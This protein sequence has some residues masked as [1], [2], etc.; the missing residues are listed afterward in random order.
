MSSVWVSKNAHVP[1][2]FPRLA[3]DHVGL[4]SD[5]A[6]PTGLVIHGLASAAVTFD[7]PTRVLH[8]A[9]FAVRRARPTAGEFGK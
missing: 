5:T 1:A 9:R 7:E 3:V 8:R 6:A 2:F 4:A